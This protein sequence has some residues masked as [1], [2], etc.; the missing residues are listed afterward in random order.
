M[1]ATHTER[2]SD[3]I[4]HYFCD[5]HKLNVAS[6]PSIDLVSLPPINK[7]KRLVPL[8]YV[9]AF[10]AL[11][12]L[13]RQDLLNFDLALY[14]MDFMGVFFL[15]FGLFKLIDLKGF[16]EGFTQYDI[17][18]KRFKSYGYAYPFIETGLGILYLVGFMFLWQN[19]L[20]LALSLIGTYTAYKYIGH[21]DEIE[22]VCLG[23]VFKL[24]MTWVTFSENF[25]MLIMVLFMMLM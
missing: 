13:A 3:N 16:V 17:I 24:P 25:L 23:T 5:H 10:I 7:H 6:K 21:A 1:S 20:V 19:L 15:V 4:E 9:F 12:P 8:M 22:C 11:V 2:D 14:M 18:T